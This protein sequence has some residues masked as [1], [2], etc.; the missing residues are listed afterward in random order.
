MLSGSPTH[1]L[2]EVE[3]EVGNLTWGYEDMGVDDGRPWGAP[4]QAGESRCRAGDGKGPR[5]AQ[6]RTFGRRRPWWPDNIAGRQNWNFSSLT[7]AEFPFS[8][9]AALMDREHFSAKLKHSLKF[10]LSYKAHFCEHR[11]N[12]FVAVGKCFLFLFWLNS[13]F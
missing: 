6:T 5:D 4:G 11:T 12:L 7:F 9:R 13:T 8:P 2:L 3:V 1:L 10:H